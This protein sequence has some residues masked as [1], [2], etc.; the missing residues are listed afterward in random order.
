MVVFFE[1]RYKHKVRGDKF[2]VF[3]SQK[4]IKEKFQEKI[5]SQY[6]GKGYIPQSVIFNEY[7]A[8]G[9][10]TRFMNKMVRFYL[11]DDDDVASVSNTRW[12]GKNLFGSGRRSSF[13]F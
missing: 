11:K 6:E 5:F 2:R 1:M 9:I 12:S 3:L 13:I 10:K 4:P 8:K 7:D